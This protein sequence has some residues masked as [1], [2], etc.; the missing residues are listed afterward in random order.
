MIKLLVRKFIADYENVSDSKV[1]EKYG[2][3]GGVLGIIC[4][5]LLF[6]LKL[7]VGLFMDSISIISDAVN[8]LSDTASSLIVL[9]GTKLSNMRPDQE[10]PFGHGRIEYISSLIVSFII[11]LVGFELLK[12][13][14]VKI[15]N[16]HQLTFSLPLII[17][18]ASSVLVK[19][20]MAS[21]N[22]YLS[23]K[24]CS[25]VLK[26]AATDSL[27]DAASTTILVIS[28]F[29]DRFV[30]FPIDAV[31]GAIFSL[32][33]MYSGFKI[34]KDTVDILLGAAPDMETVDK[35]TRKIASTEGIIGVHDLIVHDYGPGRKMASVH[36][37]VTDTVDIVKTHELIDRLEQEISGSLG[38]HMVIHMDPINTGCETTDKIKAEV[39]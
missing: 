20:W 32:V 27:V 18:L 28:V 17:I 11:M 1:R 13:S 33:V 38:I 24:I 39:L 30:S 16:P 15:F 22:R 29:L 26:A 8:N 5:F 7:I 31:M 6:I 2:V 4:N 3:L 35:I 23:G 25:G 12:S 10:H 9:F 19:L 21:Y 36:A 14:V 37:E 34:A